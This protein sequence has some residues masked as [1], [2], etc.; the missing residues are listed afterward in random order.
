MRAQRALCAAALLS[1]MLPALAAAGY[2]EGSAQWTFTAERPRQKHPAHLE[3]FAVVPADMPTAVVCATYTN[4]LPKA[5]KGRVETVIL[6]DRVGGTHGSFRHRTNVRNH[7]AMPPCV[8]LAQGLTA[9]DL[10]TFTFD[11][12]RFQKLKRRR[13]DTFTVFGAIY[14]DQASAQRALESRLIGR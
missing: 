10:V 7:R 5:N 12:S 14:P 6:F 13:H 8:N 1:S 4:D 3:L 2:S 9:G 11:M